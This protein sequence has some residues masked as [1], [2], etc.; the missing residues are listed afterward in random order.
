MRGLKRQ[1]L[2]R[3]EFCIPPKFLV[4]VSDH[5]WDMALFTFCSFVVN[6]PFSALLN[7]SSESGG[8]IPHY[9]FSL[10]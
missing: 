7:M 2:S 8:T 10:M 4:I 5:T 3:S 9:S 1:N 6:I